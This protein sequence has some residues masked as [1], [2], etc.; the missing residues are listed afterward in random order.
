MIEATDSKP[1][2]K[3]FWP[4]FVISLPAT[5]VV[6]GLTTVVIAVQNKPDIVRDD[7]YKD[8]MAIQVRKERTERAKALGIVVNY[9]LERETRKFHLTPTGLDKAATPILIVSLQHP[10]LEKRDIEAT[11]ALMPDG[12]YSALLETLPEGV[13]RAQI[14]APNSDWQING[15]IQF[16]SPEHANT[17]VEG[18]LSVP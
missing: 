1:W 9:S 3:Q 8:G 10:T 4:W 14:S 13:Y 16:N 11:A 5:A 2:Y 12:R 7:W 18:Q 6:A 17:K 15:D